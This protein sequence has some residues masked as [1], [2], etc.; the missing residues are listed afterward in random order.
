MFL[1]ESPLVLKVSHHNIMSLTMITM[2]FIY[3][4]DLA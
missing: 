2:I 3:V 1:K 4:N